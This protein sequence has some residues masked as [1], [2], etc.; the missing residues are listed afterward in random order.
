M[1]KM[2]QKD[3]VIVAAFIHGGAFPLITQTGVLEITQVRKS[4]LSYFTVSD[5]PGHSEVWAPYF[6]IKR[7]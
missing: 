5:E 2:L 1:K 7:K 3:L 4:A 6:R